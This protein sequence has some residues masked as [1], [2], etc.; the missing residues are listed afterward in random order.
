MSLLDDEKVSNQ[1][2]ELFRGMPN[3]LAGTYIQLL[4]TYRSFF[5]LNNANPDE[6]RIRQDIQGWNRSF[7]K[8]YKA[9]YRNQEF[10]ECAC[11]LKN[12]P[13][14]I[15]S[16]NAGLGH[17]TCKYF[18]RPDVYIKVYGSARDVQVHD[19]PAITSTFKKRSKA[20]KRSRYESDSDSED[21]VENIIT[22]KRR[23]CRIKETKPETVHDDSLQ[24]LPVSSSD[25]YKTPPATLESLQ[26]AVDLAIPDTIFNNNDDAVKSNSWGF[27]SD[28]SEWFKTPP[29]TLDVTNPMFDW[30]KELASL[31]GSKTSSDTS[32]TFEVT[33][34]ATAT[35]VSNELNLDF[36]EWFKTPVL[37]DMSS[38]L[39]TGASEVTT[40]ATSTPTPVSNE[41][42]FDFSDLFKTP[43]TV[44]TSNIAPV[45]WDKELAS[46]LDLNTTDTPSTVVSTQLLD[47]DSILSSMAVHPVPI[48]SMAQ[49]TT[50]ALDVTT[51]P[52]DLWMAQIM[53]T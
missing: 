23:C 12:T 36:S 19:L 21:Q 2:F 30:D 18:M 41:L 53:S 43:V 50:E 26:C 6:H 47:I 15:C 8:V 48:P 25:W 32:S 40:D 51:L 4:N 42:N 13:H 5:D 29:A 45:D 1:V 17:R 46:I 35:P 28:I 9:L 20:K 34:D 14:R 52:F 16:V 39:T 10:P 22:P 33:T 11:I 44:D 27:D 37:V 49:N 3:G 31:L 7:L 38:T 24:A